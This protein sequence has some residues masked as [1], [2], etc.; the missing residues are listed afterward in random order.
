[1][2]HRHAVPAV[3]LLMHGLAFAAILTFRRYIAAADRWVGQIVAEAGAAAGRPS[4]CRSA[5]SS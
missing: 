2:Q 3:F 4:P 5:T 1:V